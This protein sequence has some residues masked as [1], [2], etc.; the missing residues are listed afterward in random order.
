M[1]CLWKN[2]KEEDFNFNLIEHYFKHKTHFNE[3]QII[4]DQ[5]MNDIDF[6]ELFIFMDRTHSKIGQQYLY[7]RLLTIDA[8]ID[9]REQ[10]QII[11]YFIKKEGIRIK[12]QSLL[13]KL[14]RREAYYISN[15]FLD[16]Y[17]SKPKWFCL[18]GIL[19]VISSVVLVFMLFYS[20]LLIL[21]LSIYLVNMAIH[22]WNKK[23]IMVYMDSIPQLP[24]FCGIAK[25]MIKMNIVLGQKQL[26][27]CS[28]GSILELK[29]SIKFFKIDTGFKS[30]VEVFVKFIWEIT[31]ILFLIEPLIVFYVLEKLNRKREDIQTIFEYLGRIDSAISVATVRQTM[32]Y[33][34]KPNLSKITKSLSF[35]DIY[36][37][38]IPDCVS[39]SLEI[40]N[41]SILLTGS[42]MSGK[43]TFIRTVAVNLLLAQA[44]N[45]CFAKNL[46]LPQTRLFS[47]IRITDD[48]FSDKSYYFEEVLT[49]KDMIN[50]SLS[51]SNNVFFLD[52][53]FKGTNTIERIAA[54][55]AVLSYLAKS[56][57]NIVFVSTHD[58]ELT[59]LLENT[60][61]LYHFT[62]VIQGDKIHFDYMLKKG[63]L[64]TKNA[65]RI[66]EIN[67]YPSQVVDEA[68]RIS[69]HLEHSSSIST[70]RTL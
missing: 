1:P 44:I 54:G 4:S 62:E 7:D 56:E 11:D 2:L 8:R 36:H 5:T 14:N 50:E 58:I 68:K 49:V 63:N 25:E 30:E 67:G 3:F 41:K 6:H 51:G 15:L 69:T 31:K 52:E 20:K 26:I 48:L 29:N 27:L 57:N 10:E 66:L 55:K 39:N 34:C 60:F 19:S 21:L 24:V 43:T 47:A 33:Y 32:P 64:S 16:R 13:S 65:I 9:F 17:I 45:T 23:N 59:E 18:I 46:K 28:I 53:I 22:F 12:T 61:D 70:L 38:L 35:T 40:K 37:P 42:N